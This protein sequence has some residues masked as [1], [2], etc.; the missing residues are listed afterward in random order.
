MKLFVT[1]LF[2]VFLLFSVT[3]FGQNTYEFLRMNM[4]ARAAALGGSFVS[5]ND[6]PNV[7]FYN[8]AGL[9]YLTNSPVSFS[10]VKHLVDINLASLA[11]ST[12]LKNIGRIGVAVQYINY[13][14][15]IAADEMGNKTGRYKA[16]EAAFIGGYS[17]ILA[18]QFSYG[19]NVKFIYS[20]IADRIST[21]FAFDVG[22]H[23]SIP[24]YQVE[25][26]FAILNMGSQ[27]KA[28]YSTK[29]DLPLNVVIGIS[30]RLQHLPLDLFLDFHELNRRTNNFFS[31]FN[32]FSI[33]AEFRLS[34]ALRLRFGYN[35]ERRNELRIGTFAGL[36]GF[37][38]G[39]GVIISGYRFDYGYSS[40]GL[41]GAVNR[42]SISTNL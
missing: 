23:Y 37:N 14:T 27:I 15:F 2:A 18:P 9:S 6:D 26:G 1:S 39:L 41:I 36:A 29:E 35:N 8:P 24:S 4:S 10:F 30:K 20:S 12:N 40:L 17:N 21:A 28:Y 13:G 3:A 16:G 22:L 7:I 5:D 19:V 42:I 25:I 11:Y 34:K 38:V 32:A 33:G 31:K